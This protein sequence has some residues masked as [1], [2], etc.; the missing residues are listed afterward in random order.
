MSVLS[1]RLD[2]SLYCPNARYLEERIGR[3]VTERPQTR[4]VVLMCSGVNLIDS[5]GLDSLES[6]RFRLQAM[7]I[8]LHL[9]EVKGPVMDQLRRSDF[10]SR[11][12]G[13]V[14]LS[15]YQALCQ[16]DPERTAGALAAPSRERFED[17]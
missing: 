4:H 12:H 17:Y 15:Q 10:L 7:G 16:L 8:V 13:P 3:L 6:I 2:E 14:F 11:L 9:S 5:S 1:V